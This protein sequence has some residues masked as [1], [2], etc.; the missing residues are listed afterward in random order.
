MIG[1]SSS[2]LLFILLVFSL[3]AG[4]VVQILHRH[5]SLGV[6]L[7]PSASRNVW[8]VDAKVTFEAIGGR[9]PYLSHYRK[10]KPVT[11]CWEK[12]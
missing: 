2:R 10:A 5:L 7:L 6:P 8:F 12:I 1:L 4:G 3:F 11:H 9:L